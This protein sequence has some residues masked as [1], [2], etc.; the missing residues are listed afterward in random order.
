MGPNREYA[1]AGEINGKPC[2][3]SP[4]ERWD[5]A[6]VA[7]SPEDR[8]VRADLDVPHFLSRGWYHVPIVRDGED[9]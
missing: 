1:R 6:Y 3:F 5:A 9:A 8:L 7:L 2:V 4:P